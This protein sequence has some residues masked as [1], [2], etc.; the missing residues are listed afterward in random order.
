MDLATLFGGLGVI[1]NVLWPL[2]KRRKWLLL[3][4]I[5]ACAIMFIHF[6]LLGASTGAA[7]M[8]V[9]GLQASLAIPLEHKPHFKRI[10][11]LSLS[12]TPVVCFYT[13]QGAASVFSSLA[14]A[15]FCIG[16]LQ[17]DMKRLRIALL[18]CIAAWV[19]HN[20]MVSSYPGLVS[21]FLA[22]MT[23]LYALYREYRP[24]NPAGVDAGVSTS[25]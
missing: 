6:S 15:F 3:G 12:L 23:S 20:L 25:P 21:N 19:G 4:Q 7:V 11:L 5:A 8:L 17:T 9:A 18:L 10:Y 16:N 13:W 1:A 24:S 2:I 22:G 14:L